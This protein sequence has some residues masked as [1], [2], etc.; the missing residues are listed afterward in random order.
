MYG[1]KGARSSE[2]AENKAYP[3]I[4]IGG[5]IGAGLFVGSGAVINLTGPGAVLSYGIAG[6]LVIL[7]MRMLGEMA[8]V[9]PDSGSFDVCT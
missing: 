4:S 1:T 5:I 8:V 2:N 6:L 7:L 3:M 9:N